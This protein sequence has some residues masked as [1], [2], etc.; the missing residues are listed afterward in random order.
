MPSTITHTYISLDTLNKVKVKPKQI[1]KENIEDYKTFAQG[2]DILYFYHILSL[3]GNKVIDLGHKF[4]NYKTNEIFKYII[5][6]NKKTKS[7]IVFTFLSGLITHYVADSTIHPY[8]N[9]YA[10]D[11][12][13]LKSKDKHFEIETFIDNYM[14]NKK[15][16][17]YKN[18]KNYKLQFNNKKNKEIIQ[19][20]NN[21]FKEFFNYENM[22]KK[23][24]QGKREMKFVFKHLRYDK[25]GIKR[26]IYKLID[27]NK[28]KVRRTTY[29][30]YNFE[31]NN[32]EFYLNTN[33][34]Q[35][36]YLKDTS[37][38]SN[39][40]FDNLYEVVIDKASKIINHLYDYIF[41]KK[42]IDLDLLLENR[43]YSNGLPLK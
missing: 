18:Y 27:K 43:S 36:Y 42:E 16:N 7:K 3:K 41:L 40:S 32:E 21:I 5:E 14:V 15:N 6:Y 10:Y 11:K 2:M 35:W 8:V 39:Q 17:Y 28:L 33:N 23:Y 19:L 38:K 24:F 20:I 26:R 12:D 22:G 1:I 9:F 25:Y 37:I 34:K 31:L 30:S 13:R 29:L 4:H